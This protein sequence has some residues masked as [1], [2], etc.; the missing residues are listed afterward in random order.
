MPGGAAFVE[1]LRAMIDAGRAFG[2]HPLWRRIAEGRLPRSA[3]RP[4]A[5]QFFLQVR[6]FPR[7]VSALHASCPDTRERIELAESLYEEETGRVS[8]C[9]VSH[10]EHFIRFGEGVGVPRDAMESGAPLPATVA[11]IDWFLRSTREHPFI[12]GA[13][14]TNL[15]AEGQVPGAF[16]PFQYELQS[17]TREARMQRLNRTVA[18]VAMLLLLP[19]ALSAQ[20]ERPHTYRGTVH[21]VHAGSVDLV[22]GVGYALRLVHL[23]MQPTTHI[24]GEGGPIAPGDVRPGDVMRADC[25][26]TADGI[27]AERIELKRRAP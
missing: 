16:G 10:P 21:A 25:R 17:R 23:R 12:E 7:A 27:V 18:L 6:E 11:L 19:A 14:A 20:E 4:F 13:A 2:R 1:G 8:G 22:T 5:V 3:L 24:S 9:N 15:A 26:L